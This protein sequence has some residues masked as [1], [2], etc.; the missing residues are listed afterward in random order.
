MNTD[1]LVNYLVP[2]AAAILTAAGGVLGVSFRDADA[3]ERRR[4]MWLFMLVV[5]TGIVTM[6]AM[7]SAAGVGKPVAAAGLTVSACAAAIGTHFLWRRVVPDAEPRTV[8]LARIAI[9]LAVAVIVASVALTYVAGKG[10]RQAEPLMTTAWVESG[11]AQPGI[12]GRGPTSGEVADW[13]KRIHADADKVTANGIRDRAQRL[14]G[15][16][17]EIAAAAADGDWAR[18]ALISTEYF[19]VLGTL[20][21]ECKPQ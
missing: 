13:A 5:A 21:K 6:A 4:A 15:I 8:R 12:P 17:D 16:A 2:V 7:D 9:G 19:D 10:C 20:L 11:Y 14:A 1:T 18:Q 3:Y